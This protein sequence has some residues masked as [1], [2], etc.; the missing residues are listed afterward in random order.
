M[1]D[2]ST[3][4][5][6][7]VLTHIDETIERSREGWARWPGGWPDDIESALI[8]AVFS[9]RAVYT[10]N[11]GRGV[12]GKVRAWQQSRP[13][14]LRSL[15]RLRGEIDGA[16]VDGWAESFGSH[17]HS[18][19]RKPSAPNGPTKVAAVREAADA[20]V[21]RVHVNTA[22]DITED[23]VGQVKQTLR[24]VPGIGY[25]TTNYFLML[26]G[27]P[28]VKPDRMIHRFLEVATGRDRSNSE[29]EELVTGVASNLRVAPHEL[30]HAIW[31]HES[32][33]VA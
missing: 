26:L 15:E 1:P 19:G 3:D 4:A 11:A 7:Q 18:P 5:L 8:D 22:D 24:S 13:D 12:L 17:Q 6:G 32:K 31:S 25:A 29:A 23:N 9:A 33:R 27:R 20:L 28:G 10:T 2:E 16:G 30:E 21:D 14:G